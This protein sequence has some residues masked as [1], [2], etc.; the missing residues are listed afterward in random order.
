MNLSDVTC[1][2]DTLLLLGCWIFHI[3]LFWEAACIGHDVMEMLRVHKALSCDVLVLG[4][5]NRMSGY[6][7]VSVPLQRLEQDSKKQR[8]RGEAQLRG[9]LGTSSECPEGNKLALVSS[10]M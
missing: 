1:T 10:T 4:R 5:K 8:S 9:S 6:R 7:R 3:E 2:G